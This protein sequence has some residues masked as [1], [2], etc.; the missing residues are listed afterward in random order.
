MTIR[1]YGVWIG[2]IVRN[3]IQKSIKNVLY[4]AEINSYKC[5]QSMRNTV[6]FII[7]I[8][9]HFV[10]ILLSTTCCDSRDSIFI[11]SVFFF[12]FNNITSLL[13]LRDNDGTIDFS[14][15]LILSLLSI[16]FLF[17]VSSAKD[18]LIRLFLFIHCLSQT[19]NQS[20]LNYR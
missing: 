8:F 6:S 11:L 7:I 3:V 16:T 19:K 15:K 12:F 9:L 13:H 2:T 17:N 1:A 18:L 10:V 5:V 14:S 20:C 4:Y